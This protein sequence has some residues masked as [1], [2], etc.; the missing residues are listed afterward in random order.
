MYEFVS[1]FRHFNRL[2]QIEG[3]FGREQEKQTEKSHC[4]AFLFPE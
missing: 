4:C 2:I 3:F 1:A